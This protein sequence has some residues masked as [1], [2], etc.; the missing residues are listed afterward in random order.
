MTPEE[1]LRK[2]RDNK[3]WNAP[4]PTP[5]LAEAPRRQ[6]WAPI[7]I[8][9]GLV[10]VSAVV[11]VGAVSL[12]SLPH[13][14][15]AVSPSPTPTYS[16][17]RPESR[18]GIDCSDLLS[19]S[20]VDTFVGL[21]VQQRDFL[22]FGISLST[23]ISRPAATVQAG[24]IACQWSNDDP[25]DFVGIL[26]VVVPGAGDLD[27]PPL[28][29]ADSCKSWGCHAELAVGSTWVEIQSGGNRRTGVSDEQMHVEFTALQQ[30]IKD[31]IERAGEPASPP[32]GGASTLPAECA[33]LISGDQ[34][35]TV[36]GHAL[37]IRERPSRMDYRE[38]V[39]D[40][41]A[42]ALLGGP[43]YCTYST[44]EN[45]AGI[46]ITTL[47]G[48]GWMVA[49]YGTTVDRY[50]AGPGTEITV[51]GLDGRGIAVLHCSDEKA[52]CV[53]DLSLDG[54]WSSI[55]LASPGM[56]AI[57]LANPRATVVADVAAQIVANL[58]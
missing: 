10:A 12:R 24:G 32:T 18:L 13:A 52:E 44:D 22:A 39:P 30:L 26:M 17:E 28:E 36:T 49:E 50:D 38:T 45:T 2:M 56:S 11:I 57:E 46:N 16:S 1:H 5:R 6:A 54:N 51:P 21:D 34:M 42:E 25:D 33:G 41:A 15:P 14:E 4:D 55:T 29:E 47:P 31:A 3:R 53:L 58:R 23:N 37:T 27:G 48:A 19:D 35:S 9:V 40:E 20:Q 43:T 7:L 8:G